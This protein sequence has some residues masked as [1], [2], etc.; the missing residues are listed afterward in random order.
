MTEHLDFVGDRIY[1]HGDPLWQDN[2]YM[3]PAT[4][5]ARIKNLMDCAP[6]IRSFLILGDLPELK[7]FELM[8]SGASVRSIPFPR[9]QQQHGIGS[10]PADDLSDLVFTG[11]MTSYRREIVGR[12]EEKLDVA[13]PGKFVFEHPTATS[14]AMVVAHADHRSIKMRKSDNLHR[15][16]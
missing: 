10:V 7:N 4:Q 5:L 16:E 9:L 15:Y 14:L 3:H 8:F 2:D 13:C 11:F 12:L 6:Y 1:I